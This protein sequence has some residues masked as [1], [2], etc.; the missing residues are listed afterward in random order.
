MITLRPHQRGAVDAAIAHLRTGGNPML[1]L[2]TGSGKA[3]TCAAIAK[4]VIEMSPQACVAI[5]IHSLE[6]VQQNYDSLREYWPGAPAG[7]WSAS[8]GRKDKMKQ[9]IVGSV[10]SMVGNMGNIGYRHLFIVDEA[11]RID[12]IDKENTQYHK[13]FAEN[14]TVVPRF[15]IVGMSATPWKD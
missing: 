3:Y 11:H 14:R 7:I 1:Q 8:V 13:M 6:L 5:V 10:Q 12:T 9:V 4:E 15:G 2:P